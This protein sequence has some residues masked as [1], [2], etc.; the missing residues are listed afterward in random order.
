M[1]RFAWATAA[2]LAAAATAGAQPASEKLEQRVQEVGE[3]ASRA[4]VF[5]QGGSG[6]FISKDGFA[7]TNHHVAGE[8]KSAQVTL[9]DGRS[10]KA[11]NVCTDAVGDI[12]LF[13][14]EGLEG[15][16]A[17]LEFA[18]SD[19][20]EVGR[21][22][23][24]VGNPFGYATPTPENRWDPSVSLGIVSA[25][26]RYQQQYSD[27]IQ[28]DAAVNPGNSG[29]P[30]V[31]LQ[32]ELVG[33]NG[34]IA[35][36]YFN[37]VNSGVGYAISA[38]Q[39]RNFLP[40]MMKGGKNGKIHHG[41]VTGLELSNLHQNGTG[42]LVARVRPD[43]SAE[44][45]GFEKNDRIVKVNDTP[46][47]SAERFRGVVG[48]YPEGTEIK[49]TVLRARQETVVPVVLDRFSGMDIWGSGPRPDL[50][51]GGGY[52]GLTIEDREEGVQ[53]TYVTPGSPADD[54]GIVVDDILLKFDGKRV[55]DRIDLVNRVQAKKPG[56]K[57][58][59]S[60]QRGDEMLDV[61]VTL[62]KR[63]P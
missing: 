58:K 49:V 12:A 30:L 39:I 61:E 2:L 63:G 13:K 9:R 45:T 44:K 21:Y 57:V 15:D 33:I 32:G 51:H 55:V 62:G 60:I 53:V 38:N 20:L 25:L 59:L 35:T 27:C 34:R 48:T 29:G 52:L 23:L 26:H 11:T 42:A 28:T 8:R 46:I 19:R 40:E 24:A 3:K 22:V 18:D 10:K 4:F 37:R 16:V 1:R 54:A 14:V 56:T 6:V 50:P 17:Y 41:Q 43:S 47:F 36:R 7:L 5:F 31:S